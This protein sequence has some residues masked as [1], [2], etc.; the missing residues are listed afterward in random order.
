MTKFGD[1]TAA[2]AI[3]PK[4]NSHLDVRIA[5]QA[6]NTSEDAAAFE[7]IRVPSEI[8]EQLDAFMQRFGLRFCSFDFIVDPDGLWW[9]LEGN[10]SGQFLWQ[11]KKTSKE[12]LLASFAAYLLSGGEVAARTKL[13]LALGDFRAT[14]EMA[15]FEQTYGHGVQWKTDATFE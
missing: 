1:Y 15:A 4:A 9:W 10:E 6:S 11:E 2:T 13:T 8:S 12:R 14:E 5:V 3:Y 7:S